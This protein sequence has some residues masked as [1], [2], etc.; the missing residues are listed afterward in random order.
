MNQ[1]GRPDPPD[2]TTTLSAIGIRE[3]T[4]TDGEV[5]PVKPAAPSVCENCQETSGNEG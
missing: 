1:P 5:L 4:G 3:R 2:Q